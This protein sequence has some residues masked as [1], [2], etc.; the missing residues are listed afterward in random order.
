MAAAITG[1]DVFLDGARADLLREALQTLRSTGVEIEE[2]PTGISVARN[3]GGLETGFGRDPALPGL[4]HRS[5]GAAHRADVHGATA[6]RRC[7]RPSSR[8]ASCM[9]R[10]WRGSAPVSSS[11]ATPPSSPASTACTAR[12][13]WRPILRASVSLIIAGLA[14]QGRDHD[15]P[16]LSPRPRLRAHRGQARPMRRPDRAAIGLARSQHHR[17][18]LEEGPAGHQDCSISGI[19]LRRRYEAAQ[20][21]RQP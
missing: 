14:A 3:G 13:S 12:R 18:E 6:P 17:V 11:R 15:R 1:G 7:A 5:A 8:T 2:R 9:C 10:S 21:G 19:A 16:C 20:S 4:P